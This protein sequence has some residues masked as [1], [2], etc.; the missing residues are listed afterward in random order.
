MVRMSFLVAGLTTLS[1]ILHIMQLNRNFFMWFLVK[2]LTD[3]ELTWWWDI[4][5]ML[6]GHMKD[7]KMER[8]SMGLVTRLG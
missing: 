1:S 8:D 3:S 5:D 6:V 2:I 7:G 4:S